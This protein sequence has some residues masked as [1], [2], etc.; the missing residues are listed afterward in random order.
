MADRMGSAVGGVAGAVGS[1][2]TALCC[3]G[4][5]AAL[6][7]LSAAGLGFLVNDAILVPLLALLLGVTLWSLRR[8]GTRHGRRAPAWAGYAGAAGVVLGVFAGST[9][10]GWAG[11]AVLLAASVWNVWLAARSRPT[12]GAEPAGG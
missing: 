7:I 1:G 4:A 11:A 2:F 8:V 12:A 5:P 10:L 3:L 6:G 9:T